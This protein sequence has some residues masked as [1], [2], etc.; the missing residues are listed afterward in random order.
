MKSYFSPVRD[1]LWDYIN[2]LQFTPE[3]FHQFGQTPY[4]NL[5]LYGP[6]GSGKSTFVYRLAMTL[7]R[8][9]ISVD[10]TT[11]INDRKLI[12]QL[13]ESPELNY[14][15][16]E[17]NECIF[18]LEEFDITIEYL[19][20]MKEDCNKSDILLSYM[21]NYDNEYSYVPNKEEIKKNETKLN[22]NDDKNNKKDNYDSLN[23][24]SKAKK[25]RESMLNLASFTGNRPFEMNDLLEI[26]QGPVPCD[27]RIIIATTNKYSEIKKES[28]ALFRHGRLTPVEVKSINCDSLQELS[29]Y[30]FQEDLPEVFIDKL[31]AE[32]ENLKIQTSHI[33]GIAVESNIKYNK[34]EEAYHN[35]I[36]EMKN[37]NNIQD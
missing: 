6:P 7:Q 18:L 26:F 8:H 14:R 20:K 5:L 12:Y 16:Y 15:H 9:I 32:E 4:L 35:F 10:I 17:P 33:I 37:I 3:K 34:K 28:P 2:A 23:K 29:Q 24:L 13:F 31:F 22:K 25:K 19:R 21:M 27:G 30:Y 11:L 36:N 1:Q